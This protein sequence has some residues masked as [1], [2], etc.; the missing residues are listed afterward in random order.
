MQRFKKRWKQCLEP[1]LVQAK[2]DA[3]AKPSWRTDSGEWSFPPIV[4]SIIQSTQSII[5]TRSYRMPD[6][7][8]LQ[9]DQGALPEFYR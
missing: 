3:H 9:D 5:E 4:N 1:K 2:T 6:D 7:E 8:M